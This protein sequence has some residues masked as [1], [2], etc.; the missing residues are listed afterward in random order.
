M[1]LPTPNLDDR[2]FA[3]LL[4]AAQ[5]RIRQTCP[6]W[7]DLSPNEPGTVL[8]ELFAFLTETMLY[9]LNRLPEKVYIELLNLI[10]VK[11]RPP[12]AAS[13]ELTFSRSRNTEKELVIPRNTRVS[14][15]HQGGSTEPPI[16][17]T[18]DAIAMKA[19]VSEV[20]VLA[21]HR[22]LVEAELLG[23]GTGLAGQHVTV[24]R[25]PIL[26]PSSDNL[27]L[28]I[29]VE[30]LQNGLEA[31]PQGIENLKDQIEYAGK[32]Y[33]IWR[34]V[35]NF[36]N[37]QNRFVYRSDRWAGTIYFAPAIGDTSTQSLAEIPAVGSEIRA[38]Y[39]RGGGVEG[40]VAANALKLLKDSLPGL[41]V[42][43]PKPATGGQIAETLEHAL[44]RGPQE[45]H[46]LQRA[47][48][49]RDYELL[50][51]GSSQAIVRAKAMTRAKLWTFASPGTVELVIVPD[52]PD[53]E[54]KS[55]QVLQKTLED[56]ETPT[57][58]SQI[59]AALD[60][61]RPLGTTCRVDWARYKT[62][63]VSARIVVGREQDI[64][65][66][67]ER[68]LEKLYQGISPLP[69][70]LNPQGWS[71]GQALRAS[72]VY[73]TALAVPGTVWVDQVRFSVDQVPEQ[74]VSC[75]EIDA[76]QPRTWY[77]GAASTVFRSLND[78]EGWESIA[79]F[80][81]EQV[82]QVRTHP[83]RA[84]L[85]AVLT[86]LPGDAAGSAI[87]ISADCGESWGSKV[88][89]TAF[90]LRDLTWS[91]RA[92]N[93]VLLLAGDTGLY[94]LALSATG[95][96]VPLLVDPNDQNQGFYSVIAFRNSSG[97]VSVVVVAQETAGVF[98][99]TEGGKTNSFRLIGH[100]GTDI[101]VLAIQTDG[102]RAFLWV[103]AAA[104]G[105]EDNGLGCFRWELRG[106]EDPP[107]GWIAF[108]KGWVGGS[109]YHLAFIDNQVMAASHRAGVM[110]LK[111]GQEPT[112]QAADV[113]CGLP[114][115][116]RGRFQPV[117][118][119]AA[120]PSR[121]LIMAGGAEG[122]F[123]QQNNPE[124][125]DAVDHYLKVSGRE[126]SEF[127][128]LPPTWLFCSGEHDIQVVSEDDA[129]RN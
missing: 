31:Q 78:G 59:Q 103:A 68:V 82:V 101:R 43:N 51:L 116:D 62:V 74:A 70:Q 32:V 18:A 1:P 123:L 33:R 98:L 15:E 16:F 72:H 120:D 69:T 55:G 76:F 61:R 17:V 4:K 14:A 73:D 9:R 129:N 6:D 20:Q 66:M 121:N 108:N 47:V 53:S 105:P 64:K 102:P 77:A 5:D 48:T 94:E 21:Y 63:R 42:T 95:S 79:T 2:N 89:Q 24:K 34:E 44:V 71:F 118:A 23:L 26:A 58:R 86:R 45:L 50:A 99:S 12:S 8:L 65:L 112:W 113:N 40:N 80:D 117:E 27:D 90:V 109:C 124:H 36:S 114:L 97:Q 13:V 54:K 81:K 128:T 11:I 46:S 125:P 92:D 3:E 25:P 22:E 29:G 104:A 87:R 10:G 100:K 96:P 122:V 38:W 127:V 37:L 75:L 106:S 60:E 83:E 84:G 119:L 35:E 93:P 110:R 85:L 111:L 19:G 30:I 107:D 52:L 88:Y 56:R 115:R 57:A 91:L 7:T 39:A 126:F 28:I 67:K 49:A 41:N